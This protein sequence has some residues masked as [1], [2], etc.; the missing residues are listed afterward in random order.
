VRCAEVEKILRRE[1]SRLTVLPDT[2]V[3]G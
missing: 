2:S 3:Y 1:H